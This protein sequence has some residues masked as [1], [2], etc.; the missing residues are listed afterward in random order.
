[1]NW[2]DFADM[3]RRDTIASERF[4]SWALALVLAL[5]TVVA[6]P[7]ADR[8]LTDDHR[9]KRDPVFLNART[10]IYVVQARP[11][12]LQLL[13]LD[14]SGGKIRPVH[15]DETRSEL[16]PAVSRDGRFLAF[17]QSR[18]AASVGMV[19][20][21]TR[22]KKTAEI[23]PASGFSGMRS[24]AFSPDGKR[25]LYVFAEGGRQKVFSCDTSA[26]DRKVLVDSSGICN[27]P[28]VSPDGR[29]LLFGS[30]RDGNYEIYTASATD[31]SS[32][33]RLTIDRS[34]DVRP[35][36]SPDGRRVV[37]VSNR[38]GN[39]EI[40]VMGSDGAGVKRVTENSERDDFPTWHPDGK[41]IVYVSERKGRFD[42]RLRDVP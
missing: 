18:S 13:R 3:T 29:V 4:P 32:I 21:D 7:A 8:Q 26:G 20:E 22:S 41:R 28:S 17:L 42:L 15:K 16:E 36:F 23:P 5:G 35:R 9:Y 19:I 38:D 40:Y 39:R 1:M 31:G 33:R 2:S 12:Q 37:F 27:W 14:L 10:L 24:P 6:V 25:V 34:Q 11:E 30:T